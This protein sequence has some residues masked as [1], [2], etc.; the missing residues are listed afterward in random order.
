MLEWL[1]RHAWKACVPQ[2][3]IASSN[4]ALSAKKWSTGIPVDHFS[5]RLC[6][7]LSPDVG[8]SLLWKEQFAVAVHPEE[9]IPKVRVHHNSICSKAGVRVDVFFRE[10]SK[11]FIAVLD[12]PY[13]GKRFI[14]LSQLFIHGFAGIAIGLKTILVGIKGRK[15]TAKVRD[16][17]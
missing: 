15:E 5:W 10:L 13:I 12:P 3:G 2:K 14:K 1:K 17:L 9:V 16:I 11:L 8:P 7:Y 6:E 4:L